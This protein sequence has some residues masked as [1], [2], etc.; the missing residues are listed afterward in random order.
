MIGP[1]SGTRIWL[2]AGVT[3]MRR[4]FDGYKE[5]T[6]DLRR[7]Y[8]SP[9]EEQALPELEWFGQTSDALYPQIAKSWMTHWLNLRTI[10]E[11]QHEIRNA[12]YT[13]NANESLNGAIRAATKRRKVFPSDGSSLKLI[14]LAIAQAAKKWIVPIQHWRMALNRF[15]IEFGDPLHD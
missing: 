6:A 1:A 10:Y 11:Y 7:I 12:I 4:G 9:T 14:Y 2:A 15:M 3:D 5:V 8:Q 13:T